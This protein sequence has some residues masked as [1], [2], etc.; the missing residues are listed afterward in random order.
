MPE[1]IK[2]ALR[3]SVPLRVLHQ[4]EPDYLK[5]EIE[6]LARDYGYSAALADYDVIGAPLVVVNFDVYGIGSKGDEL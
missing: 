5:A 4:M 3:R 6:R 2:L 1:R